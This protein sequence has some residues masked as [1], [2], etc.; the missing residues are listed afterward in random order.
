MR[1]PETW[2]PAHGLLDHSNEVMNAERF[3][4]TGRSGAAQRGSGFL[5]GDIAGD[6]NQAGS[7][8]GAMS[9]NPGIYLGAIDASGRAH[10]GDDAM[11]IAVRQQSQ[12]IG[13][14]FGRN[15]RVSVAFENGAYQSHDG[16]F[17]FDQKHSRISGFSSSLGHFGCTPATA[18]K[19]AVSD[20]TGRRTT[21]VAPSESRL[22]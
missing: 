19:D 5:V 1:S 4:H 3:F 10:V 2:S 14:G 9:G 18:P 13:A 11:K 12:C 6:K 22:L 21:K 8:L 15:N 20:A 7:Q 17:V 16:R